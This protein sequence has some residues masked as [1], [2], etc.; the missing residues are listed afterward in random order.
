[1]GTRLYIRESERERERERER[2]ERERE[3]ERDAISILVAKSTTIC[4]S[5]FLALSPYLPI[6]FS[7]PLFPSP[8]CPLK[9]APITTLS[10]LGIL[11][12]TSSRSVHNLSFSSLNH[13]TCGAYALI[14]VIIA[15]SISSFIYIIL[16]E[17]L[18]TSNT[19]PM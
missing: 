5:A 8:T 6:T 15:P 19:L 14:T 1:M 16:S 11:S 12:T 7:S 2:V 3:R 10:S 9:S 4:P 13:P 17:T 18:L